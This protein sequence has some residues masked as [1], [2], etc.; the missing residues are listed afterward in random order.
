MPGD[1]TPP[2]RGTAEERTPQ[3]SIGSATE[4]T[5]ESKGAAEEKQP[6]LQLFLALSD[7]PA[8]L[9]QPPRHELRVTC[10]AISTH[11]RKL[12]DGPDRETTCSREIV[13]TRT[14]TSRNLSFTEP[15]E[16]WDEASGSSRFEKD[17]RPRLR[18]DVRAR[19]RDI[20][21]E[22][23][24]SAAST[25]APA[26]QNADWETIATASVESEELRRCGLNLPKEGA[27]VWL[28]LRQPDGQRGIPGAGLHCTVHAGHGRRPAP[29]G[30]QAT[31]EQYFAAPGWAVRSPPYRSFCHACHEHSPTLR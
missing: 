16:L 17:A 14:C 11:P 6:L 1:S 20:A 19:P 5:A 12:S 9:S 24:A 15:L 30:T 13:S 3:P 2:S 27:V 8:S 29:E 18:F 10:Y 7:L 22:T 31:D 4:R 25:P 28:P 21:T 23:R 26:E